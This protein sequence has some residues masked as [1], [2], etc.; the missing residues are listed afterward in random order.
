MPQNNV[1]MVRRLFE[2]FWNKKNLKVV[3]EIIAPEFHTF[4]PNT[5]DMGNGP[6]AYKKHANIYM[7]AFPDNQLRI[8]DI[9]DGGDKVVVRW[10]ATGTHRGD[11]RGIAP[12]NKRFEVTG[13][14]IWHCANGK[15]VQE[16]LQWDALGL[17]R[18]LGALPQ[19]QPQRAA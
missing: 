19:E 5:P 1:N 7:T 2:E 10:T 14:S 9:V 17:M 8:D 15:I 13:T 11:L 18:Q 16:W 12:T 4:D 6:E 3:D